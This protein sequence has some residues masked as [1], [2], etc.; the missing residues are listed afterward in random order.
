MNIILAE[1][2]HLFIGSN[3]NLLN[4]FEIIFRTAFMFFYT[5][6]NI[7][8]MDRRS[9][10]ML[11]PFEI[12]IIIA[13]G[14]AVG[15]PMFYRDIPLLT[16]MIV[17]TT[18]VFAE[19]CI[20]KISMKSIF[21]ERLINGRPILIIKN[22]KLL[23]GAMDEQNIS[24]DELYSILRLRG[25]LR[26]ADVEYAYLEPS[27]SVSIIRKDGTPSI[28]LIPESKMKMNN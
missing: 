16:G 17:I 14:S 15:D 23:S 11:S 25:V 21:F 13:L 26:I 24:K 10:G 12:I 19:R 3:F 2:Y 5:I 4:A 7:R 27:G 18:I 8:L 9:M 28:D 1:L 6:L 22:G 20:T